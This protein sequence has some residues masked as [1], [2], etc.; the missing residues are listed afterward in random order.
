MK[1]NL[2][3]DKSVEQF[4]ENEKKQRKVLRYQDVLAC[5]DT[6]EKDG[7]E[8]DLKPLLFV[9]KKLS[10]G[11]YSVVGYEDKITIETKYL[12]DFIACMTAERDRFEA[13]LVRMRGYQHRAIV[14]KASWSDIE[15]GRY[16]SKMPF[17]AVMGSAMAFAMSAN[18]S[19]LMAEN[20]KNAGVM[21]AR[22]LWV[23]ANKCHR[24][25]KGRESTIS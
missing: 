6:R 2:T 22:L 3:I 13:E 15:W 8:L 19:I 24:D 21:V 7:H 11:D 17:Q 20:H 5:I 23:A 12:D 16:R 14:I 25:Q 1:K 18:V 4:S 10:T 9:K